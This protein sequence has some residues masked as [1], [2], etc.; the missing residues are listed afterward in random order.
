MAMIALSVRL[1]HPLWVMVGGGGVRG[2]GGGCGGAAGTVR[3]A[4]RGV[5]QRVEEREEEGERE[6]V[7]RRPRLGVQWRWCGRRTPRTPHT[8]SEG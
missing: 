6:L 1:P 4:G 8:A 3:V 7:G 2:V 5:S